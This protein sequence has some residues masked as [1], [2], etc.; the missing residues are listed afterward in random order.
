[1]CINFIL[2]T[3]HKNFGDALRIINEMKERVPS[4]GRF[5][6][7]VIPGDKSVPGCQVADA[8]A[9]GAFRLEPTAPRLINFPQEIAT[10]KDLLKAKTAKGIPVIRCHPTPEELRGFKDAVL[11]L[12]Q[13]RQRHWEEVRAERAAA[14]ANPISASPPALLV[15]TAVE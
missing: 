1:V 6:G 13:Y 11:E 12:R 7:T 10:R 3:G 15:S 4:V 2:E 8:L 5:L 9:T 14:K